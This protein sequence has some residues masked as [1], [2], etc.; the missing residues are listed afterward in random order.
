MTS[1]SHLKSIGTKSCK[2]KPVSTVEEEV[3]DATVVLEHITLDLQQGAKIAIVGKNGAGKRYK[4]PIIHK[5][6]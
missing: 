3:V 5:C 1:V 2:K 6:L 4:C